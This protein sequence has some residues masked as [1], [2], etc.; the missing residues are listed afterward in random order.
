MKI[1]YWIPRLLS[2]LIITFFALFSFDVFSLEGTFLE[3]TG[4]FLMH[5]LPTI[6]LILLLVYSW[7]EEKKGGYVFIILGL[8]SIIF[9]NTYQRID[10][11]LIVSLP[12]IIT[13]ILF[14][15]SKKNR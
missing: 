1:L 3:K 2:L 9:F 15:L 4:G 5:S 14:I 8:F 7:K 6:I 10:T 11:F 13:G 12:I